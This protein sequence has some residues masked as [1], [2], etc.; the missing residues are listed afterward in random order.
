MVNPAHCVGCL[1]STFMGHIRTW[2]ADILL[3]DVLSKNTI[4]RME[5]ALKEK[6]EGGIGDLGKDRKQ[7]KSAIAGGKEETKMYY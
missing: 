7:V 1:I 3:E 4:F 2:S 6:L 5:G